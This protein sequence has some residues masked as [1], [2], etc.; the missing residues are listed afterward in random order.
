MWYWKIL[1][2]DAVVG[3]FLIMKDKQRKLPFNRK[4]VLKDFYVWSKCTE[5]KPHTEFYFRKGTD[6]RLGYCKDCNKEDCVIRGYKR[7]S[8]EKLLALSAHFAKTLSRIDKVLKER[9]EDE[10]TENI[11]IS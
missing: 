2:A 8:T 11:K 6:Y 10:A 7:L 5:Q 1:G 3:E 4:V 9:A